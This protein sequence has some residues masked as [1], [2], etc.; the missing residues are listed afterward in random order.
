MVQ[1]INATLTSVNATVAEVHEKAN[2]PTGTWTLHRVLH[3]AAVAFG[4]A[5]LAGTALYKATAL[6][7]EDKRMWSVR[8]WLLTVEYGMSLLALW[9]LIFGVTLAVVSPVLG[10]AETAVLL[11]MP[12]LALF[13]AQVVLPAWQASSFRQVLY[14]AWSGAD[15]T[16]VSDEQIIGLLSPEQGTAD[17][18]AVKKRQKGVPLTPVESMLNPQNHLQQ[19]KYTLRHSIREGLPDCCVSSRDAL[20]GALGVGLALSSFFISFLFPFK[21]RA[22][23]LD[24]FSDREE[25]LTADVFVEMSVLGMSKVGQVQTCGRTVS[26]TH[27]TLPTTPYV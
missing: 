13:Y 1:S 9:L 21:I 18:S 26:Y 22:H 25:H 6:Y 16:Q 7:A 8:L 17:W 27:L 2:A 12:Q 24:I 15:R 4:V 3:V 11:M 5:A 20:H 19:H 23:L 10:G 14:A